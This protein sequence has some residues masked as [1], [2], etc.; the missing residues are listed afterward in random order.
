[1]VRKRLTVDNW[2]DLADFTTDTDSDG[3]G[4]GDT[5]DRD[6]DEAGSGGDGGGGGRSGDDSRGGGGGGSGGTGNGTGRNS[7]G[8]SDDNAAVVGEP[9]GSGV[10]HLADALTPGVPRA[11]HA[12]PHSRGS[13]RD[14]ATSG[15]PP[16][17]TTSGPPMNQRQ[18]RAPAPRMPQ[19]NTQ[20]ANPGGT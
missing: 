6:E 1:M 18:L 15:P 10:R 13:K 7:D 8:A 4:N 2:V 9:A 14:H 17:R 20:H 19:H 3:A 16:P 12:D 11:R 5:D